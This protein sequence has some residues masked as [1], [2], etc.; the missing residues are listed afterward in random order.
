MATLYENFITGDDDDRSVISTNWYAQTFTPSTDHIIISVKLLLYRISSP[1]TFTVSIRATDGNGKPTGSDLVSGT[2]SG[3]T[4][5]T[6]SPYEWREITFGV[7]VAVL[8][9]TKYAIVCRAID[10]DVSNKV[11]WRHKVAGGYSGGDNRFSS[12]SGDTWGDA[13]GSEDFMF[14][15]WGEGGETSAPSIIN[16]PVT[17]K[18]KTTATGNGNVTDIGL[19][20]ATQYGHVWAKFSN[21]TVDNFE[22]KTQGGAPSATGAFTSPLTGLTPNTLYYCRSY[23]TNG[24]GTFYGVEV[25][26]TTLADVPVMTTDLVTKVATTTAQG[27]GSIDNNG[28]SSVT[29]YGVCWS[30]SANPTTSDSKTLEGATSVIGNFTSPI[31]SLSAG[32]LYHVRAYAT[33]SV[34]TG[35]GDDITFTTF[36]AFTPIV[37]T[38][39]TTSV[40]STT[41]TGNGTIVDVRGSA[42]TEHGHCWSTSANPTTADSKTTKGVATAGAFTSAVT[43][44]TPGTTYYIRAYATN[45]YGTAYGNNDIINQ[46]AGE[47]K[48]NI[49]TLAEFLVWTSKTG[50]QRY[51]LGDIF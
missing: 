51:V 9:S 40:Q 38:Q 25:T 10:G 31:I 3:D 45:S 34:G 39:L 13:L 32:T 46:V 8:A 26:F 7:G 20:Y 24:L 37:T 36:V 48:G 1:G 12:D 15:E 42:V 29:Q 22:G 4:L 5:P 41:A 30:T 19:P 44:L 17:D 11:L 6:G 47:I 14:E 21:P 2:T 35:Y 50:T 28:G 16:Q 33:N 18:D 23:I 27:N 49:A 43:G